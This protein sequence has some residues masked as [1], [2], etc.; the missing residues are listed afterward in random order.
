[1]GS[2]EPIR[3]VGEVPDEPTDPYR[4]RLLA[5][6]AIAAVG[7][8]AVLGRLGVVQLLGS[9]VYRAEADQNRTSEQSLPADRGLIVDR[10]DVP[11][12]R[13]QAVFDIGVIPANLPTREAEIGAIFEYMATVLGL[14]PADLRAA[15]INRKRTNPFSFVPVVRAQ[16]LEVAH[17]I[18][19]HLPRLPGVDVRARARREYVDPLVTAH[20]TGYVGPVTAEDLGLARD[21]AGARY[22]LDDTIGKMGV[23]YTREWDLRGL[24]GVRRTEVDV[25]GRLKRPIGEEPSRPGRTVRVTIDLP[26]QREVTR[27][28]QLGIAAHEAASVVALD[29]RNGDVIAMVHLPSFDPNTLVVGLSDAEFE[30][31]RSSGDVFLNGAITSAYS[32]GSLFKVVTAVAGLHEA[33]IQDNAQL[34]CQGELVFPSRLTPGGA[35]R[36]PCWA[37]H[38]TQDC[39][40]A[41][42]N[43]CNTFFYQVGAGDPRGD[44]NG[45]GIERLARW[46]R[47]LGLGSLTG[48]DLP[49]EVAGLVPDPEWKR[50]EW[51]EDWFKGDSYNVAIGQGFVTITPL[52]AANLIAT[53]A[54]GGRVLRPRIVRDVRDHGTTAAG[55]HRPV[56]IRDLGLDPAHLEIVRAGLRASMSLGRSP[57]GSPIAGTAWRSG[58]RDLP[59]AGKT[60]TA[61]WVTAAGER[62]THGWFAGWA[63]FRDPQLALAVFLRNGRGGTEAAQ[64][65][66][67]MFAFYF[68]VAED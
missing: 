1:M 14:S 50:R 62:R 4:R 29:P 30:D 5:F 6:G 20:V 31:L 19:E 15:F 37:K 56:V 53:V 23:E 26:F 34:D 58:L 68:G 21:A 51:R 63:P 2:R 66:R 46:A 11:L 60:G 40:S 42:A 10:N 59:M 7:S 32:P 49:G 67:N 16:S 54:N 9:D 8:L 44:W 61:E 17:R 47:A 18:Q 36:F 12:A 22:D 13:N 28:L 38:G 64:L 57:L 48:I 55:Q 43:S 3:S 65:A 45:L 35:A 27:L 25:E 41:L 24:S 39:A 33:V 52:Q